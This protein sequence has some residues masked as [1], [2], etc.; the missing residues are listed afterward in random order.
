MT[1]CQ[2]LCPMNVLFINSSQNWLMR[3][4]T[5]SG[6]GQAAEIKKE[7]SVLEF[8][9]PNILTMLSSLFLLFSFTRNDVIFSLQGSYP[10]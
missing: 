6:I 8:Y 2:G 9:S 10:Y 3:P 5:E 1:R 7:H 4:G